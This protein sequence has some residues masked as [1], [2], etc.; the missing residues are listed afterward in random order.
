MESGSHRPS[1]YTAFAVPKKSW[2]RASVG[3]AIRS[4]IR[5]KQFHSTRYETPNLSTGKLP[6]AYHRRARRMFVNQI[7]F[8]FILKSDGVG[9][10]PKHL[11]KCDD[12]VLGGWVGGCGWGIMVAANGVG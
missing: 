7:L 11:G 3:S 12:A 5:L 4:E 6:F 8:Y 2:S 10:L 9:W 1:W